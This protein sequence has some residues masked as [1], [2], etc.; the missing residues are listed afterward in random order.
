MSES[1]HLT[2]NHFTI[3][4]TRDS[5]SDADAD[6]DADLDADADDLVLVLDIDDIDA[7]EDTRRRDSIFTIS[8]QK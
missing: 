2:V 6:L 3:R 7:A 5:V 1:R 8:T 4:N